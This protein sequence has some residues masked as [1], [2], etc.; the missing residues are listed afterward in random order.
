MKV[1]KNLFEGQKKM[2]MFWPRGLLALALGGLL[3]YEGIGQPDRG[4]QSER[5]IDIQTEG[6]TEVQTEVQ[7]GA[8]T[9]GS[10]WGSC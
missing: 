3:A 9:G 6:Q 4:G 1:E 2:M 7:T 10:D 8:Q 5:Q